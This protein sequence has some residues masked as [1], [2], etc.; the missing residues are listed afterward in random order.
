VEK[1]LAHAKRSAEN[2]ASHVEDLRAADVADVAPR[3][4]SK[5]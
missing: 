2:A 4:L 5:V 1:E 3:L